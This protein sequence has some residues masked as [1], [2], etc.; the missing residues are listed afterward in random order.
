VKVRVVRIGDSPLAPIF[1]VVERPNQWDRHVQEITQ[2]SL[3]KSA[4]WRKD[5]WLH[6]IERFPDEARFG[7]ASALHNRWYTQ[8]SVDLA[9]SIYVSK[10]SVGIYIR[11]RFG[12]DPDSVADTLAPYRE[13]LAEATGSSTWSG[14][15]PGHFFP[16]QSDLGIPTDP[17]NWDALADWLHAAKAKYEQALRACFGVQ[18]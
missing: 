16:Q 13:L 12:A 11:G 7:P 4:E 1:E 18:Q 15:T 14:R 6:F 17:V 8:E 5:F 10:K 2:P 3:S 9:I